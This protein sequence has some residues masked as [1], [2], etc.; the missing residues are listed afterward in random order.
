MSLEIVLNVRWML[1]RKYQKTNEYRQRFTKQK[2]FIR[3]QTG[4][5]L[6]CGQSYII[7]AP[8][9]DVSHNVQKIDFRH[10]SASQLIALIE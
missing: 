7:G 4:S 6:H 2:H 8:A 5:A 3:T 10:F 9:N 1:L